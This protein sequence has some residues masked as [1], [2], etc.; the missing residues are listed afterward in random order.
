MREAIRAKERKNRKCTKCVCVF[1]CVCTCVYVCV[2][3]CQWCIVYFCPVL[4]WEINILSRSPEAEGHYCQTNTHA[5]TRTHSHTHTAC[6]VYLLTDFHLSFCLTASLLF[7]CCRER[8]GVNHYRQY[9]L[10]MQSPPGAQGHWR[11]MGGRNKRAR[12]NELT[13]VTTKRNCM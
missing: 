2:R 8:T 7:F 13:L 5:C 9:W 1:V 4:L 12:I 3:V 6:L 11:P 10:K